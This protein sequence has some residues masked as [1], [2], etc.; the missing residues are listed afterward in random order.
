MTRTAH[1]RLRTVLVALVALAMVTSPSIAQFKVLAV[2]GSVSV[3]GMKTIK[4]GQQLST[5]DE[6]KLGRDGYI[7]M[8]HKT[9]K[10]VE[11]SKSG[12]YKVKEM[13]AT[14]SKKGKSSTSKF[15]SYVADQLT[16][17][18]DPI[19]FSSN[20]RTKMRT[21]GSVERAA[22]DEVN[23]WDS[24]LTVVGAPGEMAALSDKQAQDVQNGD[25]LAVITPTHTRLLGDSIAFMWHRSPKV[26]HYKVVVIGRDNKVVS[27]LESKDTVIV[28][29]LADLKLSAGQV[30]YW[31]LED[32]ADASFKSDQYALY[33]L[34]GDERRSAEALLADVRSDYDTEDAA[35]GKLVLA[36]AC[37]EMGLYQDAHM[38][39]RQAVELAPDVQNYKR[40]Y[41]DF[42]KRQGLNIDAYAAYQ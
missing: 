3:K 39:Y 10:A 27:T 8:V 16:E 2:R 13:D 9:G 1:L 34:Q 38:A 11:L 7:S 26:N 28:T 24:V 21:T 22:G 31:H 12:T 42:L 41:A 14:A 17:T 32:G 15:A 5:K 19:E 6:I 4:I 18:D 20:R 23:L 36:A 37:E 33:L 30:Y 29:G 40:M 25:L 35:I